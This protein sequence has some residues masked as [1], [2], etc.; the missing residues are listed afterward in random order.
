MFMRK[1]LAC[2]AA[3]TAISL[4]PVA[5]AQTLTIGL[6]TEPT[7][8][9]PHFHNLG[10]NNQIAQHFFSRLIEQDHKQNLLPGLATS[11]KPLDELTWE[12]KLRKGVKFHDGSDFDADDVIFSMHRGGNHPNARS[13]FGL[14]TKAAST[15]KKIDSH[16]L[17]FISKKPYPLMAVD[18]SNVHIVSSNEKDKW[19]GEY[20]NGNSAHGT[21]PYKLVRWVKGEVLEMERYE[22]YHGPKPHWA[23]IIIK[24]IKSAPS[25]LA[26]LLAGDVDFID[27]VPTVDIARLKKEPKVQ[28]S[29]GVSNRVIY[30][31][32]DQFRDNPQY[33]KTHDG[34]PVTKNPLKDVRVRKAL[35]MAI[36]RTA[37]VERVMEGVAIPAGQLLPEGFF[38]RSDKLKVEKYDPAG[39]KKLLVEAG[40]PNGFQV[41]LHGPNNRYIN[42]AKIVEAIAQMLT[43]IG[44]KTT[45]D[46]MPKSVF[47]KRGK[48]RGPEKPQEFNFL[49]VGW[50]SGT[51][52]PSSPLRSLL[53]TYNKT[54]GWGS[55]NRGLHSNSQMDKILDQALATVDDTKRAALLAKATEI[56]VGEDVGIIPLHY[57]VNTWAAMKGLSYKAR[58]DERTVGYDVSPN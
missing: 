39:A 18:L 49:L 19:E 11:W 50:G 41:T 34:K 26:A 43:R 46:T 44:V 48:N 3:V 2:A 6:G 14:Y 4:A 51:G 52:E 22:G 55:S 42:D 15:I 20:N 5:Q 45:P 56:G 7:S 47:F 25:R 17:H 53:G 28:L 12:F 16:T 40:Y 58:T 29:Q 30:L 13:S 32:L 8:I 10:P 36:N 54:K 35:S 21:G 24:P 37:I 38:G 9:D 27:Q 57:Q 31:H 23:K 1:T 33:V